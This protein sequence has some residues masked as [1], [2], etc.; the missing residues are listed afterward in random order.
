MQE[1]E[2]LLKDLTMEGLTVGDSR[3]G[4]ICSK[5]V[6]NSTGSTWKLLKLMM[7]RVQLISLANTL[8]HSVATGYH[9]SVM[10][11]L[12]FL[13]LANQAFCD[14]SYHVLSFS[15]SYLSSCIVFLYFRSN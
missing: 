1:K 2:F 13:K 14:Y 5:S 4:E 3:L 15:A 12:T 7:L 8:N 6:Q 9:Q 11:R 10:E